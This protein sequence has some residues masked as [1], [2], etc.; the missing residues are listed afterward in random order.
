MATSIW[1]ALRTG[2]GYFGLGATERCYDKKRLLMRGRKDGGRKLVIPRRTV[3]T[4]GTNG[5]R[6]KVINDSDRS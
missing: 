3:E 2:K 4:A 1:M 5:G 6:I